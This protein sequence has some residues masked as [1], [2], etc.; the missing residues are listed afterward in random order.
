MYVC[1]FFTYIYIYIYIYIFIRSSVLEHHAEGCCPSWVSDE[2]FSGFMGHLRCTKDV[3]V[4]ATEFCSED[5]TE[6]F[7]GLHRVE[8]LDKPSAPGECVSRACMPA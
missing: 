6:D 4:S 2:G 8:V 7:F 1:M 3:L 5:A